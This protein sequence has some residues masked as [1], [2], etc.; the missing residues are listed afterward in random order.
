MR[1]PEHQKLSQK[2]NRDGGNK[3]DHGMLLDKYGG[4]TDQNGKH[5]DERFESFGYAVLFQPHR[6]NADGIDAVH[7][8]A[9]PGVGIYGVKETDQCSKNVIICEGFRPQILTAGINDIDDDGNHLCENKVFL[10]FYKTGHIVKQEIS[11]RTNDQCIPENVRDHEIFA[12]RDQIVQGTVDYMTFFNGD[13]DLGQEKGCKIEYPSKQPLQ[14][15][16]TGVIEFGKT[17]LT[18]I[19]NWWFQIVRLLFG[20]RGP[21]SVS[22]GI[23]AVCPELFRFLLISGPVY[24]IAHTVSGSGNDKKSFGGVAGLI[25]LE[26]HIYRDK[27]IGCSVNEQNGNT[28]GFQGFDGRIVSGSGLNLLF[29]KEVGERSAYAVGKMEIIFGDVFPDGVD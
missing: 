6:C 9:Y 14:M 2:A 25:V 15:G 8:R 19:N 5:H 27:A 21:V 24:K 11:Q 26:C 20:D 13:Q 22:D 3:I 29:T 1:F 18:I 16:K 4:Q 23:F 17:K 7:G 12:E 10:Q 28:V